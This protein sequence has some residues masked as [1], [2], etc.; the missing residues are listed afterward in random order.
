MVNG[1]PT[2][3]NIDAGGIA[4]YEESILVTN[5]IGS[6]GTGYNAAH[7]EFT[8]P[9]AKT[10]DGSGG[11]RSI[12]VFTGD[13]VNGGVKL[14]RDV[15]VTFGTGVAETTFTTARAM[16]KDTRLNIRITE[17]V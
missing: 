16:P 10:Y 15:D 12:E 4:I 13:T 11:K 9:N 17:S 14:V 6:S 5:D 2:T 7:T 3:V 8:L 1:F